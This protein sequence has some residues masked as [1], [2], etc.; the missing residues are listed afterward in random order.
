MNVQFT[1][2]S[3]KNQITSEDLLKKYF[4]FDSFR[5]LQKEIIDTIISGQDTVALLPTGGGKSLC[6]QIPALALSGM[7]VVISP[8]I[9][10][11]TDQVRG[12]Q[13]RGIKAYCL[14]SQAS[15]QENSIILKMIQKNEVKIIYVAPERLKSKFFSNILKK[16]QVS[17]VVLDEAHCLSQWGH[18][19]R[20]AYLQVVKNLNW[21]KQ[22]NK[23]KIPWTA[24]TA[25]A[26]KK[27]L[28]EIKVVLELDDP[29]VFKAS[30]ARKNLNVIVAKV[31]GVAEKELM[32]CNFLKQQLKKNPKTSGIIYSATK[33]S[34]ERVSNL[35]NYYL[36]A[37]DY[38]DSNFEKATLKLCYPYHAGLDSKTKQ[39]TQEEFINNQI[40]VI[41][42]TNAFGMGVDKPNVR[43]VVHYHFPGSLEAYYQE[44]GRAGRDQQPALCLL[45]ADVNDTIIQQSF[46]TRTK[47][48]DQQQRLQFLLKSMIGYIVSESCRTNAVLKYFNDQNQVSS[49]GNCDICN[50]SLHDQLNL[51]YQDST[52]KTMSK[53]L[54]LSRKSGINFNFVL[55]PLQQAWLAVLEPKTSLDFLKI[56][57]IGAGWID[58]WYNKL[59]M[60]QENHHD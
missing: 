39:T 8:L 9:S 5:P 46:I 12:L 4:N 38:Q 7:T 19:F 20:P 41:V 55:T 42:A 30:F 52:Q 17:L 18:D 33:K 48:A 35:I 10:L 57:G 3:Q 14:T 21:L 25:T 58:T 36:G 2:Y 16:T 44:I 1:D 22:N 31:N 27:V 34:A 60:T 37:L 50:P 24:F 54:A 51:I 29:K 43:F 53:L 40:Q 6:F 23:N 28:N 26:T 45:L 47:T 11:M 13:K 15:A 56:P 59:L 49:C 32:L